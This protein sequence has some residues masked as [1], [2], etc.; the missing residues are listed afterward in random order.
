M[1]SD[2]Q[3]SVM[4]GGS[5]GCLLEEALALASK[6]PSDDSRAGVLRELANSTLC[7]AVRDPVRYDV[8]EGDRLLADTE[9]VLLASDGPHGR[10]LLCFTSEEE[11]RRRSALAHAVWT[12]IAT[13]RDLVARDDLAGIVINPAGPWAFV[14]RADLVRLVSGAVMSPGIVNGHLL[15]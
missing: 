6:E 12:P 13:I 2:R 14:S 9:V 3:T 10:S 15:I 7:F 11:L 5:A 4:R 1:T 8:D